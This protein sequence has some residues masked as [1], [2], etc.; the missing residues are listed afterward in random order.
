VVLNLISTYIY[1]LFLLM[2]ISQVQLKIL[3]PWIKI[4]IPIGIQRCN[5]FMGWPL[6]TSWRGAFFFWA[7]L[8]RKKFWVSEFLVLS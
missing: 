1:Y 7:K 4:L 6:F 2:Q 5:R 3:N 8:R